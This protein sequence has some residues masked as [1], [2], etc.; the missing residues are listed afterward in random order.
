MTGASM[1]GA[2]M[3]GTPV[4]Q[5]DLTRKTFN[6]RDVLGA[7]SFALRAGE[8]VALSGPSGCGKST[9]LRLVA[10]LDRDYAGRVTAPERIAMVFQEPRLLPWRSARQNLLLAGADPAEAARLLDDLGLGE[11]ADVSADRLSLGMARRVALARALAVRADLLLLDEPFV[12]LDEAAAA[13]ARALLVRA[14][15]ARPCAV[16]LVTHDP[17]EAAAL[18]DRILVMAGNPTRVVREQIVPSERPPERF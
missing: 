12:S 4:V 18:A 16:L 8:V 7:I 13:Q 11:A 9:L 15:Q 5:V 3:T 2:S 17:A 14:R 10:G 1:A 6:G